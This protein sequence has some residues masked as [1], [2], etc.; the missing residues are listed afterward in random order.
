[1]LSGAS[2]RA[3]ALLQRGLGVVLIVL[4]L[5]GDS[6]AAASSGQVHKVVKGE[7][8]TSVAKKHGIS[9]ALLASSNGLKPNAG[10]RIGQVLRIPETAAPAGRRETLPASVLQAVAEAKVKKGRWQRIVVHHTG[11]AEG[12]IRGLDHYHRRVRRMENG[13][14]YHF[15]IGNGQGMK[16]GEIHVGSRWSRQLDGGHLRSEAQNKVGLGICLVGNFDQAPPTTAQMRSLKLLVAQLQTRCGIGDKSVVLHREVNVVG[17]ACP[18]KLFPA[19][20]LRKE[21]SSLSP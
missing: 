3:R 11:T 10:L 16:D 8:L 2:Q 12:T 1:M 20:T 13:L 19:A 18:G 7:S 6:G 21:L 5:G 14:A 15:V 9:V 4:L 17:T